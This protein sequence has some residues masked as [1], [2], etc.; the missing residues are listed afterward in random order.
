MNK[1]LFWMLIPAL[2]LA[3]CK[4][5]IDACFTANPDG[6]VVQFNSDCSIGGTAYDWEFG[7]G[8]TSIAA[9]PAHTYVVGGTYQ[10]TLR[11]TGKDGETST[12]TEMVTAII[13]NANFTGT[14]ANAETCDTT[15]SDF[16][17]VTLTPSTTND[18]AFT[19]AGL[20]RDNTP[21]TAIAAL[22]GK[23]FTIAQQTIFGGT[24]ASSGSCTSNATGTTINLVYTFTSSFSGSAEQCTATFTK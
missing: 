18:R 20:Y 2:A 9:N 5:E 8:G 24:I 6:Q 14:Y 21:L 22:D 7:D 23:S 4:N 11:V 1:K 13:P 16:Y 12:A 17:T 10:V 15:G 3:S 19:I